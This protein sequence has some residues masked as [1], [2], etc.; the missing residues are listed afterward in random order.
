MR[1]ENKSRKG[2]EGFRS[3]GPLDQI[4]PGSTLTAAVIAAAEEGDLSGMSLNALT[5]LLRG[6][7]KAEALLA[8]CRRRAEAEYV[9]RGAAWD[10]SLGEEVVDDCAVQDAAQE[11]LLT[12]GA[13]QRKLRMSR[14]ST[15][16]TECMRLLHDGKLRDDWRMTIIEQVTENVSDE[17]IA[18][19]D[20]MIAERAGGL[21]PIRLRNLC[22]KIVMAVEPTALA[23]NTK[24]ARKRRRVE[25]RQEDSGN[26]WI[27]LREAGVP[28]T[29]A[30]KA[31][32]E[33]WARAMRNAGHT[34]SL[35]NLR[36]D[37]AI[38]LLTG[39][40]PLPGS[41]AATEQQA[42]D[43]QVPGEG[44]WSGTEPTDQ[45]PAEAAEDPDAAFYD[46]WS[47]PADD[48]ARDDSGEEGG[49]D[50]GRDR[51]G[52]DGGPAGGTGGG[53]QAAESAPLASIH[54]IASLNSVFGLSGV[55]SELAG[56]GLVDAADTRNLIRDASRNPGTRFCIT[57]TD[58]DGTAVAHGCARGPRPWQPPATGPPGPTA[59]KIGAMRDFVESLGLTFTPIARERGDPVK[60]EPR[61]DPSRA[62]S[63]LI[64]ARNATCASP[65]CG[66]SAATADLD[67]VVAYESGGPTSEDNL[68]PRHRHCH[69]VKHRPQWRVEVIKPG[70]TRWTGP[71][72]RTRI[73]YPTSYLL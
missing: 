65:G 14:Q 6:T 42:P 56:F 73:V 28:Q 61:H 69:L 31:N 55:P 32:L 26:G 67:H 19:I 3:D 59:A 24:Q 52:G 34:G 39:A 64:R 53:A 66:A 70:I 5:G 58:A 46:P 72:G 36:H 29:M 37:A 54:L 20:K 44:P 27:A 17:N 21:T 50:D 60:T 2:L 71:S 62:L 16:L 22:V 40:N 68:D 47:F 9:R 18:K 1:D 49:E 57:L 12:G 63:H 30:V 8:W 51:P 38:A 33:R 35:D 7:Q 23:E 25:I 10:P 45:D 43:R 15:Q 41:P 48:Q 4:L 13:V 11:L